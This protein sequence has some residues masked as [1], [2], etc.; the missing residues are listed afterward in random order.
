MPTKVTKQQAV[1]ALIFM[2]SLIC[3]T[4]IVGLMIGQY[5]HLGAWLWSSLATAV[6]AVVF[7]NAT[8]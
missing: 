5:S 2:A 4:V 3:A 8:K 1:I 7:Y 6:W